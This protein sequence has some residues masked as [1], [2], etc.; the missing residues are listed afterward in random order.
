MDLHLHMYVYFHMLIHNSVMSHIFDKKKVF[1]LFTT[2]K[3]KHQ[4]S[5][6]TAARRMR[7]GFSQNGR[8]IVHVTETLQQNKCDAYF[9]HVKDLFRNH[10]MGIRE[11]CLWMECNTLHSTK[12][13]KDDDPLIVQTSKNSTF[14][15]YIK[16]LF[17]Q[18]KINTI[19]FNKNVLTRTLVKVSKKRDE[20]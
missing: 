19:Q 13:R 7:K 1:L 6:D 10:T 8:T 2:I 5:D 17:C 4:S 12:T 14:L 3:W 9:S 11:A 15:Y 18:C 20:K 16:S